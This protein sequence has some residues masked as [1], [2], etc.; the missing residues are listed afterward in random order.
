MKISVKI[1]CAIL[2][3]TFVLPLS[4]TSCK[5]DSVSAEPLI[6]CENGAS[7]YV[8]VHPDK[9]NQA[10]TNTLFDARAAIKAKTGVTMII[11]SDWVKQ[12][13]EVPTGTKEILIGDTNRPESKQAASELKAGS[14]LIKVYGDRI[15]IVADGDKLLIDAVNYFV[16]TYVTNAQDRITVPGDL[17]YVKTADGYM[18]ATDNG[19][20]T[21]TLSLDTF[22]VVYDSSNEQKYIPSVAKAFA[23]RAS[24]KYGA[25]GATEDAAVNKYEILLGKCD[26]KQF[27]TTDRKFLFRDFFVVYSD[28]KLSVSASSIYGYES[29]INFLIDGFGENGITISKDGEYREYDYGQGE[30]A[31]IFRNFDNPTAKDA[32]I[33]NVSHRGDYVTNNNPE[34]S[35]LAYQSCVDNRI[36]VIETDL[37]KTKDGVWVIC[38][39]SKI[40]RTTNGSGDIKK[41][42][43]EELMQ[44][45]L[46]EGQGGENA[47]VTTQK[48]PTLEEIIEV[49]RGKCLFNLDKLTPDMFQE[50]YDVFEKGNAVDSAMFKTSKMSAK[51]LIKWY[52]DLI[53]DGRKLPAFCPMLYS[54]TRENAQEYKGLAVILETNLD[55]NKETL[56][57]ILNEC[58]MRSLCLT[59]L[60]LSRENFDFYQKLADVGYRAIMTDRTV[61]LKEFIHG[62]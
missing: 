49:A 61:Q 15:A 35:V 6:I 25:L 57:Y 43:Y 10:L 21:V 52:A 2:V 36:D 56:D 7:Q 8:F 3:L 20:G 30:Y 18:P 55:H 13:E 59:A 11:N 40:D 33:V 16:E 46:K 14:Y 9:V 37:Q 29:A 4:L 58:G 60:D 47:A 17:V 23:S 42:T 19:D 28:G 62:K 24:K 5:K 12:G 54:K 22:V 38:H 53:E 34:N 45:S 50:I 44:Y 51:D 1:L 26:R 41:M 27:K 48:I 31:D 32:W 39:D